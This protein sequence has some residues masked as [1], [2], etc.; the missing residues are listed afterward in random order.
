MPYRMVFVLPALLCLLCPLLPSVADQHPKR[1]S[2]FRSSSS[3][4]SSS[5]TTADRFSSTRRQRRTNDQVDP[6]KI[7][8][9]EEIYNRIKVMENRYPSFLAVTTAQEEYDLPAAGDASDCTFEESGTDGCSNY[10]LTIQDL[11]RHPRGSASS[12]RLPEVFWSGEVHGDERVGPTAVIEATNLLL[13]AALCIAKPR[14]DILQYGIDSAEWQQELQRALE[15]RKEFKDV[16]DIEEHEMKWLARLVSTRRIVV[17]PTANALGY[18][19]IERTE[20]GVDPNR[21]FPFDQDPKKC[22]KT[23]AARTVNELFRDHMFQLSLTFHGGT[24]VIGYEW[25]AYP[26]ESFDSPDDVAQS[27]IAAAYKHIAGGFPAVGENPRTPPY[28]TGAMNPL[29]YPVHGGMEDWAYGGSWLPNYVKPCTPTSFGGYPEE[30]TTYDNSTLRAFNMLIETSDDKIPSP[31]TL[32]SPEQILKNS[33][34][35]NGHIARNIRLAIMAAELVEPYLA[36]QS[37]NELDLSDDIVPSQKIGDSSCRYSGIVSVQAKSRKITLRWVVGGSI[38]VDETKVWY[39]SWSELGYGH[40]CFQQPSMDEISATLNEGTPISETQGKGAFSPD[41]DGLKI[42]S[43][44][45]DI[46]KYSSGV[47]LVVLISARVDQGWTVVPVENVK[48]DV[49]PQSHVVNARTNPN[50]LH[51]KGGKI[52]EGRRDWFSVPLTI[53]LG[54]SEDPETVEIASRFEGVPIGKD[55]VTPEPRSSDGKS[56]QD[57]GGFFAFLLV[58]ISL[59]GVGLV[60]R[61]YLKNKMREANRS[62]VREFIEDESAPSPGLRHKANAV[63]RPEYED[64]PESNGGEVE[65]GEYA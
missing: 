39:G 47:E 28:K 64:I 40:K 7:L 54:D 13:D 21:D 12:N 58:L 16:Y 23:V 51:E 5:S 35:G 63:Q 8:T 6:Y 59:V 44:S 9:S 37:V 41:Q 14:P 2:S 65:L 30:K 38:T 24:E 17:V 33:G 1:P 34:K 46:S 61:Q 25:G 49:P 60:G 55:Q 62:R 53:H 43:A 31:E 26:F 20:D 19:R 42:F 56:T 57:G 45:I 18:S 48:P 11:E 4:S 3:S 36:I 27:D 50:W 10:I 22:M 15:C 52:I 29:V 32:G